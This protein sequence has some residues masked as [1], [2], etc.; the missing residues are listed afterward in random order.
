MVYKNIVGLCF[1]ILNR[2]VYAC[3][4]GNAKPCGH[5]GAGWLL[6]CG[7]STL[8]PGE[9][10]REGRQSLTQPGSLQLSSEARAGGHLLKMDRRRGAG[11]QRGPEPQWKEKE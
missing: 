11:P 2:C 3:S 10:T 6:R 1:F 7:R 8:G 5:K 4:L 9:Q